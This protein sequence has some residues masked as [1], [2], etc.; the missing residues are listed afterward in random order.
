MKK[1]LF[2]AILFIFIVNTTTAQVSFSIDA[3]PQLSWLKSD[4]SIVA[5]DG[6]K[7][8]FK[9]GLNL[10]FAFGDNYA[11][12]TGIKINNLGGKLIYNTDS[13]LR[14]NHD[15]TMDTLPTG[16]SIAYKLQYLEIPLGL[17][18]KT[19]EIGYMTYYMQ[20]GL[21]PL[22]NIGANAD[23]Q[24]PN[25]SF[26]GEKI[27]KE[28]RLFSLGYFISGGFE[29]NLGGATSVLVGLSYFNG[30]MDVT[31]NEDVKDKTILNSVALN[32]GIKF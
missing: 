17:K 4:K 25:R 14:F 2:S 13:I 7:F 9:Y 12:S 19:N 11:F 32:V 10:D 3:A 28:V 18:F 1:F 30:F 23:A 21:S 6:S 22:I 15:E 24:H 29:Y 8:G 5:K 26:E 20:V 31:N 27:N 16:I